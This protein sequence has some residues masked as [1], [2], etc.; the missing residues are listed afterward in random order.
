MN[1]S[2]SLLPQ[3]FSLIT[4]GCLFQKYEQK[5]IIEDKIVPA[6]AKTFRSGYLAVPSSKIIFA[7]LNEVLIKL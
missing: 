2:A 6:Y 7:E 1:V 4:S 3:G 5:L